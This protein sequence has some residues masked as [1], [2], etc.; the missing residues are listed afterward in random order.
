MKQRQ[1]LAGSGVGQNLESEQEFSYFFS[2]H[3][4]GFQIKGYMNLLTHYRMFYFI[5]SHNPHSLELALP[6]TQLF[7]FFFV[8]R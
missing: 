3:R 8:N 5:L 4:I 1:E 6:C 7:T 2:H